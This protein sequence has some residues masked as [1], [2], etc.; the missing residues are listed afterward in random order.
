MPNSREKIQSILYSHK[1]TK[2]SFMYVF[3][4]S[5]ICVLVLRLGLYCCESIS[6]SIVI[7]LLWSQSIVRATAVVSITVISAWCV[8]VS[9]AWILVV[10][11][12]AVCFLCHVL[13]LAQWGQKLTD[14]KRTNLYR[15][16][17]TCIFKVDCETA[18]LG[19]LQSKAM[20]FMCTNKEEE[21]QNQLSRGWT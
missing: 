7:S 8:F 14:V 19:E 12:S 18:W 3:D 9:P 16:T 15:R 5:F 10:V 11:Q 17:W 20:N 6:R 21:Q 13:L 1:R 2:N 4:M